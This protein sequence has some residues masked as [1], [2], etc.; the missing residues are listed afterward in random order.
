MSND[1]GP[2]VCAVIG[3]T[4][5]KMMQAEIQEA[6]KQGAKLIELRL[7]FLAKAPDFK[8]LLHNRP[9]PLIATFRRPEDGGRWNGPEEQRLML[10]RQAVVAGFDYI[11]VEVDI[12]DQIARFGSTKR[13]V[14]YHNLREVPEKLELIYEQM[15]EE[16]ADLVKV[17]VTAQQVTDNIRVLNLLKKPPKPTV[18]LCMGDLGTCSRILGLRLGMPF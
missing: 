10:M 7:D 5:H 18:A 6:A 3:R 2:V 4:R 17:S 9:C 15:C 1:S 16:D 12:A 11:D 13:I 8:R 14:S